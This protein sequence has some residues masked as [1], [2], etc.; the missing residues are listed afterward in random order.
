[1]PALACNFTVPPGVARLHAVPRITP[2]PTADVG[3]GSAAAPNGFDGWTLPYYQNVAASA[4]LVG[5]SLILLA[6]VGL[7]CAGVVR[8]CCLRR[9]RDGRPAA[10]TCRYHT[11]VNLHMCVLFMTAV[12]ALT[13]AW[14]SLTFDGGLTATWQVF[15]ESSVNVSRVDDALTLLAGDLTDASH[16]ADTLRRNNPCHSP[17]AVKILSQVQDELQQAHGFVASLTGA[18][19]PV[20]DTLGMARADVDEFGEKAMLVRWLGLLGPAAVCVLYV[21]FESAASV[22]LACCGRQGLCCVVRFLGR[23]MALLTILS[24]AAST[25]VYLTV[26]VAAADFCAGPPDAVV[27][28]A[29]KAVPS[30]QQSTDEITFYTTCRESGSLDADFLHIFAEVD[31]SFQQ[32]GQGEALWDALCPR[33]VASKQFEAAIQ[34]AN[35][36]YFDEVSAWR[37]CETVQPMWC[38]FIS[39]GVCPLADGAFWVAVAQTVCALFLTASL[40]LSLW[41][42]PMLLAKAADDA[43]DAAAAAAAG[44]GYMTLDDD[45]QNGVSAVALGMGS[46]QEPGRSNQSSWGNVAYRTP[47]PMARVVSAVPDGEEQL[48][49]APVAGSAL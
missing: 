37:R 13:P 1:M 4:G 42:T 34:D 23:C 36:R 43:A 25:F 18:L 45:D 44:S 6:V 10:E 29:V 15:N 14:G 46:L 47:V 3:P 22:S 41:V 7:A 2:F 32:I 17:D 19:D 27:A 8:C 9:A 11:L 28:R 16:A 49:V 40:A 30:L 12:A 5:A 39:E 21:V 48:L 24:L 35:E 38:K 20:N 33:T 26:G 31:S